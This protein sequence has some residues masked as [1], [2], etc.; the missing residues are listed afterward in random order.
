MR[1][2]DPQGSH[3]TQGKPLPLAGVDL[4]VPYR[5]PAENE[6]ARLEA[7][8]FRRDLRAIRTMSFIDWMRIGGVLVTVV[9]AIWILY[10]TFHRHPDTTEAEDPRCHYAV[11]IAPNGEAATTQICGDFRVH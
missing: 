7:E 4:L 5:V 9:G 6:A 11:E 8:E 3:G 1:P 2:K 10:G